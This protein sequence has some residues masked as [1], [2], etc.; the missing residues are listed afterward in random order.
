MNSL[1]KRT[2]EIRIAGKTPSPCVF[3]GDGL[4]VARFERREDA[5]LFVAA[6]DLL[7]ACEALIKSDD[8]QKAI[9]L[10]RV[11]LAKAGAK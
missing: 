5:Q 11:A 10:A 3:T 4:A 2:L 8:L 9:D 1:M 6:S 7:A